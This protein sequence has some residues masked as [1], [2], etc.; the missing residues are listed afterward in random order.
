MNVLLIFW[1]NN[2]AIPLCP[3]YGISLEQSSSKLL[4][5]CMRWREF[6]WDM[7]CARMKTA[8]GRSAGRARPGAYPPLRPAAALQRFVAE[9]RIFL[10]EELAALGLLVYDGK[11]NYLFFRAPLADLPQRLERLGI[12]I[13]SCGNYRGLD[14]SYCRIAVKSRKDNIRLLDGIRQILQTKKEGSESKWQRQL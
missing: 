2:S 11:A 3:F 4:Q 13:R 9:E 10:Q 14:D 6:G 5:K 1:K 12:L 7:H 8:S